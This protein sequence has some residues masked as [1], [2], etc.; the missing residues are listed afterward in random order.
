MKKSALQMAVLV[1]LGLL[2]MNALAADQGLENC[3][4]AVKKEKAG[5]LIKLEKLTVAGKGRMSW[6]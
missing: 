4:Q 5:E 2:T 6:S 1:G 3:I